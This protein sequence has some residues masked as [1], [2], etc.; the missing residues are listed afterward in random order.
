MLKS[1]AMSL[2]RATGINSVVLKIK[3]ANA[4]KVTLT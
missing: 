4:S 1:A 2:S 3:A